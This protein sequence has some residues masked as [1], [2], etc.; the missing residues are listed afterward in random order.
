ME[1]AI[2]PMEVKTNDGIWYCYFFH[3]ILANSSFGVF[4]IIYIIFLSF[5]EWLK[6]GG[7][8]ASVYQT[9]GD[10][11]K[12]IDVMRVVPVICFGYQVRS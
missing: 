10:D 7:A 1:H 6:K 8:T 12:W 11:S 2:F 5:Y 4:V 3:F 9:T